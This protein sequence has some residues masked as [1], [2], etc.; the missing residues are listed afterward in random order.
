[1]APPRLHHNFHNAAGLDRLRSFQL[2]FCR[3][4]TTYSNFAYSRSNGIASEETPGRDQ[5]AQPLLAVRFCKPHVRHRFN[6]N[7]KTR[8]AR[9]G[10]ATCSPLT[11]ASLPFPTPRDASL[12]AFAGFSVTPLLFRCLLDEWR[13]GRGL[14]GFIERYKS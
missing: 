2:G 14:A 11:A 1:M 8:T 5:V 3:D 6:H 9:S 13:H 4:C 10:C 12:A 7:F